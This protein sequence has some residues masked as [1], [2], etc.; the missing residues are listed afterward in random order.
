MP[1][2]YDN[3]TLTPEQETT[4]GYVLQLIDEQLARTKE[5]DGRKA[6]VLLRDSI[7]FGMEFARAMGEEGDG[8]VAA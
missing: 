2:D 5:P 1:D 6:L 8:N 3:D 4:L 7:E